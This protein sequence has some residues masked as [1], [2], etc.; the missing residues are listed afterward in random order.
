MLCLSGVSMAIFL[1]ASASSSVE[2]LS[3]SRN[4]LLLGIALR[5]RGKG[6]TGLKGVVLLQMLWLAFQVISL[7]K[8]VNFAIS[9]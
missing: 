1:R 4:A 3:L 9:K 8:Q 6:R 5:D 2:A 7:G